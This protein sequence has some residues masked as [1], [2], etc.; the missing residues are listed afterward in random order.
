MTEPKTCVGCTYYE[1]VWSRDYSPKIRHLCWLNAGP[2][3]VRA[4]GDSYEKN[5]PPRC[6]H[7][8]GAS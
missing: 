7:Y 8:E 6:R 4:T 2:A 5:V 3:Q 1:E